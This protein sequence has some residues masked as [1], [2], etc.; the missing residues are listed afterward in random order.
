MWTDLIR[1]LYDD[2][3]FA[4]PASDEQIDQIE[5]RLGQNV[6]RELRELLAETDGVQA[7]YGSGLVWSAQEIIKQNREFRES[8]EFAQ[9]Y[10]SF[11]QLMFFG[12]NGGGD[13]F[14]YVRV[15]GDRNDIFAWDHE[16]DARQWIAMSLADY[17]ERRAGSPGDDWYK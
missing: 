9:L 16:T 15:P 11:S 2:A 5:Q 6:P 10:M 7:E 1:R 17:V 4:E 8:A 12:D 14:A 13:Q 3:V